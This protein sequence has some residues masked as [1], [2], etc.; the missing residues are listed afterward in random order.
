MVRRVGFMSFG[1]PP[2]VLIDP[3]GV[4]VDHELAEDVSSRVVPGGDDATVLGLRRIPA[5]GD[6][7]VLAVNDDQRVANRLPLPLIV[8]SRDV[9]EERP[10][11]A[12]TR[13]EE[14]RQERR[15]EPDRRSW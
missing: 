15:D 3:G 12:H 13:V 1:E 10:V 5:R 4:V 9:T 14:Q 11:L 6:V 7:G 8:L 2:N